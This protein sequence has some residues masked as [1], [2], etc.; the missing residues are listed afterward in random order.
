MSTVDGSPIEIPQ[1][2][3]VRGSSF[4]RELPGTST[5]PVSGPLPT[6]FKET[7]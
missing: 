5:Q 1:R 4:T 6:F 7:K 2:G 3:E